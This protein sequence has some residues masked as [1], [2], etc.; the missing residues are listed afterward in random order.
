[1]SKDKLKNLIKLIVACALACILTVVAVIYLVQDNAYAWFAKNEQVNANGMQVGIQVDESVVG[2]VEYY[3]FSSSSGSSY[4]FVK[5]DRTQSD[6][7][8]YDSVAMDTYDS[9]EDN[10]YQIVVKITP[11]SGTDSVTVVAQVLDYTFQTESGTETKK[12]L[13]ADDADYLVESGNPMSSVVAFEIYYA[14]TDSSLIEEGKN[15][16]GTDTIT[17]TPDSR[18]EYSFVTEDKKLSSSVSL[19]THDLSGTN[20]AVYIVI[21]YNSIAI[22]EV[23][24]HNI[25]NEV[26][27]A[28]TVTFDLCDFSFSVS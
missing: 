15:A 5:K 27:N 12:Y 10:A 18:K 1:M 13:G 11:T 19:G 16:E 22:S 28:E 20:N 26:C 9:S 2:S 24:S 6:G 21:K 25:G 17:I 4:T 14:D 23:F 8:Q 3:M 7:T